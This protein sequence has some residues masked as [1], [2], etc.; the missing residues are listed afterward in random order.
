M[1]EKVDLVA[2]AVVDHKVAVQVRYPTPQLL[3]VSVWA[4]EFKQ[5]CLLYRSFQDGVN[6]MLSEM[7]QK[8]ANVL[9]CRRKADEFLADMK[10]RVAR[11]KLARADV[12]QD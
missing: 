10:E 5:Y 3:Y 11:L 6:K 8:H 4:Q 9:E 1:C 7:K 12:S 2:S